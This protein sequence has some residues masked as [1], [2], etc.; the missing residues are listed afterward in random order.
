VAEVSERDVGPSERAGFI[1]APLIGLDQSP[2]RM[3]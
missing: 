2:A 3:M 1:E